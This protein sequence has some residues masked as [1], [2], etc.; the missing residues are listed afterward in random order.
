RDDLELYA[1]TCLKIRTKSGSIVPLVFNRP[2]L[3]LHTRLEAQIKSTGSVRALVLKARQVGIS[4]YI[5]ARYFHKTTHRKGLRTYILSHLD[6]ASDNLFGMVR[7][8]HD[9]LP[10]DLKRSTGTASAKEL[11]FDRLGSGYK[12]GTAGSKAIGRSDTIQL[13]HGSEMGFW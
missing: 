10:A 9:E 7:R 5:A 13:F 12:V 3:D 8:F 2:Q 1:R 4:T 6:D 11:A